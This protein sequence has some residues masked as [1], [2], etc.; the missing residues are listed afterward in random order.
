MLIG[1][2]YTKNMICYLKASMNKRMELPKITR[3]E[4]MFILMLCIDYSNQLP[5]IYFMYTGAYF[6][7]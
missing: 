7:L 6:E 4:K 5:Y 3:K 2:S 1:Q